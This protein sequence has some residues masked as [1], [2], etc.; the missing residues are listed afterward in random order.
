VKTYQKSWLETVQDF[1]GL[2]GRFDAL[3]L[4]GVTADE[5][6]DS[7]EDEYLQFQGAMVE[8]LVKLVEVERNK[9]DAHDLVM[10][11]IHDASSLRVL[12]RQSEFQRK[13]LRQ[14]WTETSEA[15][16]KLRRWCETYSPKLDKTTRLQEVRRLNPFWNPAGG[17]FTATLMKL[18]IGPVT[19]FQGLRR[20]REKKTNWF[21]F[22]ILII[23]LL[24]V[25][26]V[27]AIVHLETVQQMAANFGETSGLLP[28]RE[29]IV[30]KLLIHV[31][32]LGGVVILSLVG[33]VVLMLLAFLHVGT[34]HLV[35][36]LF[37]GKED[38][39]MSHK[40]IVYGAAPVVAIVT[41]PYA[42]VL[43]VI[44]TYKTQKIPPALAPLA[45]LVGTVL[46]L[47]IVFGA[48]FG[49]Y[50][51][52]G[53]IP[54]KGEYV[55]VTAIGATTYE[56]VRPR[57]RRVKAGKEIPSGVRLECKGETKKKIT[58]GPVAEFYEV[59]YQGNETLVRQ[60]D[61]VIKEFRRSQI[62]LLVLELTREKVSFVITR[63]SREIGAEPD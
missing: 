39:A 48:L 32:A 18:V 51:F 1:V 30:P 25:F 37:G 50:Y 36:K 15:L 45:W 57:S 61:G 8:R 42:I 40:I 3:Y 58:N 55:Q 22:K 46:A 11:V 17:G 56:P 43:Q 35:A 16:S 59:V 52:T 53:Q 54:D 24:L 60:Q 49:T 19:F 29:G 34:A 26:L 38:I 6:T 7:R 20:G 41:A 14:H 47:A 28:E 21:L 62:P 13:R 4:R 23:P 33:T 12:S 9:F 31:F 44:G 10:A 63:L 27:L 2:W 5:V